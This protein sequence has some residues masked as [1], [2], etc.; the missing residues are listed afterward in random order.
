M[1]TVLGKRAVIEALRGR[2]S[3]R[4][5]LLS[6]NLKNNE[7]EREITELASGSGAEVRRLSR[8]E[9]TER[10]GTDIHQG[11][12]A[13]AADLNFYDLDHLIKHTSDQAQE[14]VILLNNIQDPQNLGAIL[15][16]AEALGC[17]YVVV[18]KERAAPFNELAIKAAAGALEHMFIVKV[19]N[20][21]SALRELKK[22]EFWVVG[23]AEKGTAELTPQ[24]VDGK[25]LLVIGSEGKGIGEL[26][27]KECDVLISLTTSGHLSSLNASCA[28]SIFLYEIGRLRRE[29]L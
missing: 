6:E 21:A 17:R 18:P 25:V 22:H 27:M 14:T 20:I 3:V 26:V 29:A 5:V 12:A 28:A 2:Y 19:S 24:L 9:M 10:L 7:T 13:Y 16:S 11:V 23:T 4:Q 15:R 1:R 8:R